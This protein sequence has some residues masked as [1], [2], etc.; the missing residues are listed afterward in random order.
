MHLH[1]WCTWRNSKFNPLPLKN[2]SNQISSLEEESSPE[3]DF[4]NSET[5][6]TLPNALLNVEFDIPMEEDFVDKKD[7]T[8]EGNSGEIDSKED[9]LAYIIKTVYKELVSEMDLLNSKNSNHS[10]QHSPWG[11]DW[12][13]HRRGF[14]RQKG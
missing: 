14:W 11:R 5:Q 4:P 3:T 8:L 10:P 1:K 13:T 6:T 9:D 7:N 2:L 12:Y